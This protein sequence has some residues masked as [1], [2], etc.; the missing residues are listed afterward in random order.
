MLYPQLQGDGGE[1]A[2]ADSGANEDDVSKVVDS[3]VG[4][5]GL[6]FSVLDGN[7][8]SCD[9][10]PAKATVQTAS[11]GMSLVKYADVVR[12]CSLSTG[13]W[14]PVRTALPTRYLDERRPR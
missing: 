14:S 4:G 1:F 11:G 3:M 10:R 13:N 5:S 8:A 7:D 2:P 12:T 6:R 9:L